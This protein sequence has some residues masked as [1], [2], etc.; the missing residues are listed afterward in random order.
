MSGPTAA[1]TE[2]PERGGEDASARRAPPKPRLFHP[3]I[4]ANLGTLLRVLRENGPLPVSRLPHAALAVGAILARSPFTLWERAKVAR[5][6]RSLSIEPPIFIV[7]HWR[8][9]TTHLYN[10]LS[11]APDLGFVSPFA[12]AL[13]WDFL[14]LGRWLRPLLARTLPEH[15]WIDRIPV[16]PDSPQEDEIALANMQA[17]SF[18][19][20]LYFPEHFERSFRRGIFFDGCTEAQV[21]RW[22]RRFLHFVEKVQLDQEGRRLVIKNPVYTARIG[23]LR[24]LIPGA[25]FIHIHRNPY[26]VFHSMRNFWEALFA[27]LALQDHRHV[28]VEAHVLATYERMMGRLVEETEGL[29]EEEFLEM[30]FEAFE[31]DPLGQI[32]R[33]YRTFDLPGL[34]EARPR[35]RAYLESVRGYRKNVYRFDDRSL[36]RIT[37]RWGSFIR[38]WGYESPA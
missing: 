13:P 36:E 4:G 24:E 19:H 22:K 32:E 15:R 38:R 1:S 2:A 25:R 35:F 31:A 3:L 6:R 16:N 14:V 5:L 11:R 28:D 9:G 17:I 12:T 37:G 23:L 10:V 27:E 26:R 8:S 33:I 7:G 30:R 21:E 29:P 20:A 18:Y 34:E